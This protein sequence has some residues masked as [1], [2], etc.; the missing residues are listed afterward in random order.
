MPGFVRQGR[1]LAKFAA[2]TVA[3]MV[4]VILWGAVVRTTSSGG[5]CGNHWPLCNGDF[6]PHHPRVATIIEFTHRATTGLCSTLALLVLVWTFIAQTRRRARIA[7]VV[8]VVFLF[9][10]AFL[11]R[12]LVIHGYVENNISDARSVMQCIHFTNTMLLLGAFTLTWWWLRDKRESVRASSK[13]LAAAALVLTVVVGATGSVAALADTLFPSPSLGAA[14]ASDFAANAPLIV[15]MR[16][17]HPAAFVLACVAVLGL[18][19]RAR[20]RAASAVAGLLALQFVIGAGDVLLLAP[21]W[22]QIL[23]L[24]GADLFWIALVVLASESLESET[25][26]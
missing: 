13:P 23:H 26:D 10:E 22:L 12:A 14:I 8:S 19:L 11:G 20:G 2:A 24:L 5:G 1:G 3:V 7:A 15:R 16:W 21:Q 6:F 4:G 18:C 9:V 25:A 17:L